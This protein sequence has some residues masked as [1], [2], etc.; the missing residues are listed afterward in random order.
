MTCFGENEG[1]ETGVQES[2]RGT[3][4]LRLLLRHSHVL[5]FKVLSMPKYHTIGYCFVSLSGKDKMKEHTF[6]LYKIII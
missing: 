2:A 1:Q 4:T 6:L 5:C 3:L